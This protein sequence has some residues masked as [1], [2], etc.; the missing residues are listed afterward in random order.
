MSMAL[1]S[2]VPAAAEPWWRTGLLYQIY[3]RSFADSDGDGI[4]DL[5]GVLDRLDYLSWLGVDGLW[6][7]PVT[8]SP[9]ADWGYD[10]SDYCSVHAEYGT[11]ADLDELVAAA[12][13]LGHPG[14]ARSGPQPHERPAPVVRRVAIL[15]GVGAGATSTY[16]PTPRPTGRLPTTGWAASGVRLGRSTRPPGST[17]CTTSF[18]SSPT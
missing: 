12:G 2:S 5:Q 3:V 4:G 18:P 14:P 9:N 16:G 6:L 15:E 17:T 7:S 8:P 1:S 13:G 10:V 11:L